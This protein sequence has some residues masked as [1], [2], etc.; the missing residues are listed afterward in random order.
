MKAAIAA[1]CFAL[2]LVF[3]IQAAR[4]LRRGV[5]VMG[6]MSAIT[7]ASTVVIGILVLTEGL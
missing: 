2:G 3:A 4:S 1:G 6:V 5:T 7:A